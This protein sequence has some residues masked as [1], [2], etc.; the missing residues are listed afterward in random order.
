MDTKGQYVGITGLLEKTQIKK[1]RRTKK[2]QRGYTTGAPQQGWT[3]MITRDG[4]L[5]GPGETDEGTLENRK[6]NKDSK[7][8]IS[9]R[10]TADISKQQKVSN[11]EYS[12]KHTFWS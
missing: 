6:V 8:R 5:T 9:A 4:H 11:I 10:T 3:R 1:R 12:R 7:Q 2:R